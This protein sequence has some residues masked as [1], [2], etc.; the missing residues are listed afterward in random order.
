MDS[1][2]DSGKTVEQTVE[3]DF[4]LEEENMVENNQK[5]PD[6]MKEEIYEPIKCMKKGKAAGI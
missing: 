5:R 6:I 2:T 4:E 3:G 1:G